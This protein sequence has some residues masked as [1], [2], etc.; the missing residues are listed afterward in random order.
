V[1]IQKHL[2]ESKHLPIL[3]NIIAADANNSASVTAIDIIQ[4]RKLI[5]GFYSELPNNKSWRFIDRAHIFPDPNNPW[6]TTWPETYKINPFATSMNSVDFD[7][8]KVGDL[9]LN[10]SLHLNSGIFCR[11]V[12][13]NVTLI[14]MYKQHLKWNIQNRLVFTDAISMMLFSFH[15]IG[16]KRDIP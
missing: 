6:S 11:G 16:I 3:T 14:M 10:A 13:I 7:A 8:V 2:L 15:S 5:L 1:Q 9:N 4:I 12:Q